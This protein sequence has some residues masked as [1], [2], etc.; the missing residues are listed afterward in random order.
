M[1]TKA[2]KITNANFKRLEGEFHLDEA[3][4]SPNVGYWMIVQFGSD[5]IEGFLSN[6][7]FDAVYLVRQA[8]ENGW[9][10]VYPKRTID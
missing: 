9:V 1:A 3:D 5:T 10:D 2:I 8:L 6:A 4:L 7:M